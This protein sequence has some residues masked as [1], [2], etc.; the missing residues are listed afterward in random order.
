MR[1]CDQEPDDG[2]VTERLLADIAATFSVDDRLAS[3]ELCNRLAGIEEAPWGDWYGKPL[4]QRHLARV[5]VI[6]RIKPKQIWVDG[7][8]RRGYERQQFED[9]RLAAISHL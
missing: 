5:S 7:T 6:A 8:N 1:L 3:V 4:D 9:T 2:S